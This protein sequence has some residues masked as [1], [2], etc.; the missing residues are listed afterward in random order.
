M[1]VAGKPGALLSQHRRIAAIA[2]NED[3]GW[4]K[5]RGVERVGNGA[6]ISLGGRQTVS[7]ILTPSRRLLLRLW[8][9]R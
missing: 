7:S 6:E 2:D 9:W 1:P 5:Y 3:L 4:R 8:A